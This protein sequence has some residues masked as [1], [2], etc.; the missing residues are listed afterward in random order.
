MDALTLAATSFIIAVSLL[1]T[2]RKDKPKAS[3]IGLC[4]AI[5][6]SQTGVFLHNYFSRTSGQMLN[7]SESWLSRPLLSGFSAIL[8]IIDPC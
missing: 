6:V 2:D 4:L 3:F 8:P 5:F 1:I 7:I